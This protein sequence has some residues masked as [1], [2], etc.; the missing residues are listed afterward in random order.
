MRNDI[1]E[2]TYIFTAH[3]RSLHR[4][5]E[6]CVGFCQNVD[7]WSGQLIRVSYRVEAEL[8]CV[9]QVVVVILLDEVKANDFADSERSSF[10]TVFDDQTLEN[11]F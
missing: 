3:E 1:Q 5:L 11:C 10:P 9:H 8:A 6:V 4:E 2:K 7:F